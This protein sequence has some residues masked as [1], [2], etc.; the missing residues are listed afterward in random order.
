MKAREN[1]RSTIFKGEDSIDPQNSTIVKYQW[2]IDDDS[3]DPASEKSS[4]TH[5]FNE[6]GEFD[7]ILYVITDDNE[8]DRKVL[9]ITVFEELPSAV[10][11]PIQCRTQLQDHRHRSARQT[12]RQAPASAFVCGEGR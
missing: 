1:A 3:T 10:L 12:H 5:T 7:I 8:L 4:F 11:V 9:S 6:T 2:F